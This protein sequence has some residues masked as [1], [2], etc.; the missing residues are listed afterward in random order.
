[1]YIYNRNCYDVLFIIFHLLSGKS[2]NLSIAQ[3][4]IPVKY[5]CKSSLEVQRKYGTYMLFFT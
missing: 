2:F 5:V 1:M 3:L 4:L